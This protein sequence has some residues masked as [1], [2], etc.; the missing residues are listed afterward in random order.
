MVARIAT[1]GAG[2][3]LGE[4][5]IETGSVDVLSGQYWQPAE[6]SRS[7]AVVNGREIGA[8]YQD[9][10]IEPGH[11]YVL[12]FTMAGNPEGEP[13]VKGM[14]VWWGPTLVDMV[15]FDVTGHY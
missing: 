3:T 15:S 7:G 4:W 12:R 11:N 5:M 6:A 13:A 1:Y 2:Q 9:V 8:V 14:Q 10:A